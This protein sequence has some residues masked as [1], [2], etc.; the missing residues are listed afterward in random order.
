MTDICYRWT[1]DF[2]LF[3]ITKYLNSIFIMY[4]K[5]RWCYDW[6]I[7]IFYISIIRQILLLVKLI[8]KTIN[9]KKKILIL[10]CIFLMLTPIMI[11]CQLLFTVIALNIH[12]YNVYVCNR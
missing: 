4:I 1:D 6:F 7:N 8:N 2:L 10:R 5:V 9:M 11:R 3:L 12:A